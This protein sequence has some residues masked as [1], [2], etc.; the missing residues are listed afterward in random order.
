MRLVFAGV[1]LKEEDTLESYNLISGHVVYLLNK[2]TTIARKEAVL[3]P[4]EVVQQSP[5]Y[6]VIV[7]MLSGQE[8]KLQMYSFYTISD[9]MSCVSAVTEIDPK[10]MKLMFAGKTLEEGQTLETCKITYESNVRL[11][12]NRKAWQ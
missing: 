8:I 3:P 9:M 2:K 12:V 4:K 6:E 7:R 10:M 1:V 5:A 11:I